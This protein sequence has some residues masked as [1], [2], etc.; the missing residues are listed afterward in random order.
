MSDTA[1]LSPEGQP[2]DKPAKKKPAPEEGRDKLVLGAKSVLTRISREMPGKVGLFAE[3]L[4]RRL[5]SSQVSL[6]VL[7]LDELDMLN[8]EPR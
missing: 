2:E 1:V 4:G 8:G 5:T 6:L 7:L 3:L